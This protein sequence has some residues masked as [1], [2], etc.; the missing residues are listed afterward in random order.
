MVNCF[1]KSQ[2]PA[3]EYLFSA[4]PL[5]VI[6]MCNRNKLTWAMIKSQ[7]PDLY[8]Y[9]QSGEAVVRPL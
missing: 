3:I 7:D 6:G 4:L 8:Q 9:L 2:D 1:D 5:H